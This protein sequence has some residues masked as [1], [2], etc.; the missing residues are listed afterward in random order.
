LPDFH[1][2]WR[3]WVMR[4]KRWAKERNV[5]RPTPAPAPLPT[6]DDYLRGRG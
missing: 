2:A 1:A 6:V 4:A 5:G 3:T